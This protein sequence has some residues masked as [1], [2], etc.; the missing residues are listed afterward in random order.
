[1]IRSFAQAQPHATDTNTIRQVARMK[2]IKKI[3]QPARITKNIL[4]ATALIFV[5]EA[6]SGWLS[7][8]PYL[9]ECKTRQ[10]S[11]TCSNECKRIQGDFQIEFKTNIKNNA[12]IAIT[13]DNQDNRNTVRLDN[14]SVVDENNWICEWANSAAE[15]KYQKIN[16]IYSEEFKSLYDG[17]S[18]TY[19]C[20]K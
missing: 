10:G 17:L 19:K 2:S 9:Y 11:F 12:V 20:A 6:Q 18:S 4:L 8:N 7:Q 3:N 13:T 14:C 1:V 15:I 16:G 5:T